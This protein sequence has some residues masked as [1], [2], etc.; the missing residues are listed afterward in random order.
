L[1][2]QARKSNCKVII[3]IHDYE[4]T[5]SYLPLENNEGDFLK[6]AVTINSI[7]D[8]LRLLHTLNQRDN[9]IVVGMG[10]KGLY[11]RVV[12]PLMGSFLTYA[13]VEKAITSGQQNVE[14][15]VEIYKKIGVK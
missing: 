7:K 10:E 9:L 2:K 8:G 6:I 5:P 4:K 14:R 13:Y 11:T 12:A 3:S 1:I 15:L